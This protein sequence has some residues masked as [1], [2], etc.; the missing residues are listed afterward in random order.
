MH[1]TVTY[2]RLY[3]LQVI[4]ILVSDIGVA[5]MEQVMMHYADRSE[6]ELMVELQ[7]AVKV[8]LDSQWKRLNFGKM[9]DKVSYCQILVETSVWFL[10]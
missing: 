5:D 2:Q 1:T 6:D 8:A 3:R 4:F 9:V 10:I 7:K